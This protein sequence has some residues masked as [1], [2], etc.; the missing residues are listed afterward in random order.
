MFSVIYFFMQNDVRRVKTTKKSTN[1]DL[2]NSQMQYE[3]PNTSGAIWLN[4]VHSR[5]FM[6]S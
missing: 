5:P 1:G 2:G 6:V 4:D 3:V